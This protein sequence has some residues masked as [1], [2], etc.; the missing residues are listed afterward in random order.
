ME[1]KL[2]VTKNESD[3]I[4]VYIDPNIHPIA[5]QAKKKS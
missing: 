3:T 1:Y 4:E 5:Y 2:R